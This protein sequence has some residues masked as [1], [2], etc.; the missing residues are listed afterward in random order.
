MAPTRRA[1]Q[2]VPSE[3]NNTRSVVSEVENEKGKRIMNRERSVGK[4]S[5]SPNQKAILKPMITEA[6][7]NHRHPAIHFAKRNTRKAGQPTV[8]PRV[9]KGMRL[10]MQTRR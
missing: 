9:A 2:P 4:L 3:E 7:W 8:I 10:K 5:L 6:S 1:I